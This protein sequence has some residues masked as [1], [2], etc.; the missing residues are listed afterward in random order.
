MIR[1]WAAQPGRT[2]AAGTRA[3]RTAVVFPEPARSVPASDRRETSARAN[4]GLTNI[5]EI[6][7]DFL[8]F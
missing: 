6:D 4:P 7:S 2:A 3:F 8:R 5:E 1:G